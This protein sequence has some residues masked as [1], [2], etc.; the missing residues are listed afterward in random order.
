MNK[1]KRIYIANVFDLGGGPLVL[2]TLCSTLRELGY[3]AKLIVKEYPKYGKSRGFRRILRNI[4]IMIYIFL[5][6][7]SLIPQK[8]L[9]SHPTS[10]SSSY[11]KSKIKFQLLPPKDKN[12]SIVIYPEIIYGNPLG[13]N[14]VV[15]WL[16]YHHKYYDNY[17]SY[18][19]NDRFIAYREIFN[20]IKLNPQKIIIKQ[21]HFDQSLYKQYNFGPRKGKCYIIRKGRTRQDLP[22][23]FDG[24]VFDGNMSDEDFVKILNTCEYCYSYDTQTFY[25]SIASI[26]GCIPVVIMEPG[27]NETDYLTPDEKHFG[28]AY[29]DTPQQIEYAIST[30]HLLLESLEFEKL[31]I[32]NAQILI[33]YLEQNFGNLRRI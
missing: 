4:R 19:K 23:T 9:A 13:I 26:C 10:F 24:P 15:R 17:E 8:Y 27:K 5:L 25:T 11:F 29:G 1:A 22:T 20:D 30:R 6:T 33:N 14:N 12:N 21:K 2:T 31:N 18:E 32:N 28:V 16:L 3:D 7:K